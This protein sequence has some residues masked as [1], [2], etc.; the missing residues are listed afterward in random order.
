MLRV[1]RSGCRPRH[2]R[3]RRWRSSMTVMHGPMSAPMTSTLASTPTT[4][5]TTRPATPSAAWWT[6]WPTATP[7]APPQPQPWHRRCC[8]CPCRRG[9]RSA[10]HSRRAGGLPGA[11]TAAG[12]KRRGARARP[13]HDPPACCTK[14]AR[15][16]LS[17]LPRVAV[18]AC[19]G[20]CPRDPDH[21]F[22][23]QLPR[24]PPPQRPF[25]GRR[26][27]C[28]PHCWPPAAS[29]LR[30]PHPALQRPR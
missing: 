20:A 14:A 30:R 22:L 16:P 26:L 23:P 9:L 6:N 5:P 3:R 27:H 17:F 25:H 24:P 21:D 19:A 11:R 8:L 28:R 15:A 2:T 13:S 12:L 1:L 4:W 10:L 18:P 7:C 29:A